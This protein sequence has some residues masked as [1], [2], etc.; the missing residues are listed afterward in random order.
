M[1]VLNRC[2]FVL[3]I[4]SLFFISCGK[5][6]I[7][8]G[9]EETTIIDG[10]PYDDS[11]V[12]FQ[13]LVVTPD[14][15][16][17]PGASVTSGLITG[18]TD[19]FGK[20]EMTSIPA[21]Q[22]SAYVT[23]SHPDYHTAYKFATA[24]NP[25]VGYIKVRMIERKLTKT[26]QASE[27]G[28]VEM[29]GGASLN[30]PA[31]GFVDDM[32]NVYGGEVNVYAYWIDPVGSRLSE[33]MPGDLRAYDNN[34]YVQLG[35]FGMVSVDLIGANGEDLNLGDEYTAPV[36][37]PVPSELQSIAPSTIPLWYFDEDSGYWVKEGEAS[38]SGGVYTANVPH[39]SFWNC[40]A[41][42]PVVEIELCIND[43]RGNP[44]PNFELRICA[45]GVQGVGY[46]WTDDAGCA[47][48]KIPK[49]KL[50]TIKYT[51][52]CGNEIE[53]E[54]VGPFSENT[55]LDIITLANDNYLFV[56]EGQLLGCMGA[57]LNDAYLIVYTQDDYFTVEIDEEGNFS[58]P[59]SKCDDNEL[60][61]V[62]YD[63]ENL[64]TSEEISITDF[65]DP[66]INLGMLEVCD[67]MIDEYIRFMIDGGV[68]III[69]DPE[70]WINNG[71]E[72]TIGGIQDGTDY[73]AF[74]RIPS[75]VSGS[76]TPEGFN[77]I[78]DQQISCVNTCDGSIV[79]NE[80]PEVGDYI[81]GSFTFLGTG[82]DGN[83]IEVEGS[84]RIIVDGESLYGSISGNVFYDGNMDGIEND[85]EYISN[86]NVILNADTGDIS[87]VTQTDENGFYSFDN[88]PPGNYFVQLD[89]DSL[90]LNTSELNVGM[91]E[92]IDNDFNGQLVTETY[93]ITNAGETYSDIDAGVTSDIFCSAQGEGCGFDCLLQVTASGGFGELTY[94]WDF[95][96]TDQ[97]PNCP[98][99]SFE[100][101]VTVTDAFGQECIATAFVEQFAGYME[102]RVWEDVDGDNTLD[103]GAGSAD[104]LL[105]GLNVHLYYDWDTT[106]PVNTTVTNQDGR[107]WFDIF[108]PSPYVIGIEVPDGMIPVEKDDNIYGNWTSK[109][110]LDTLN[111]TPFIMHGT[112][113]I[114]NFCEFYNQINAGFKPQ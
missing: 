93:T 5:D 20:F 25:G 53:S 96:S 65:S 69:L 94:L 12:S 24:K 64:Y 60:R 74:V 85:G 9:D 77:F 56:L 27:G 10:V 92:T 82:P 102:G 99:N 54:P 81:T 21:Q 66:E 41:P 1:K 98:G 73:S 109:V 44:I 45:E 37:F 90:E 62:A 50:L 108:D 35:T 91:D 59:F 110:N 111:T 72:T 42:F 75:V 18:I 55:T 3:L 100:Y 8:D 39:F 83:T 7:L 57:P 32:G 86:Q 52:Q 4:G 2:F 36:S 61:I 104:V 26:I 106:N 17:L 63:R 47:T 87:E 68:E 107:Y 15:D 46:G 29:N 30:L 33:E 19:E 38:L 105:E 51:D 79:L 14:G 48:G 84:Y 16:P 34:E 67:E 23:I 114:N 40:D 76:F 70:A 6:E 58:H 28:L 78:T 80:D 31:N 71:V 11:I 97:S 88:L 49:D 101:N 43:E 22:R 89:G 113:A 13:G 95:G 103:T 112:D